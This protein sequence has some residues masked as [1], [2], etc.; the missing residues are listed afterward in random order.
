MKRNTNKKVDLGVNWFDNP[1]SRRPFANTTVSDSALIESYHYMTPVMMRR[2]VPYL[3]TE[4]IKVLEYWINSD[5]GN[6]SIGSLLAFQ[7]P[8]TQIGHHEWTQQVKKTL[9][10]IIAK[11]KKSQ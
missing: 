1:K 6:V 3:S 11:A 2:D 7:I 8:S 4:V 5:R 9:N 10:T